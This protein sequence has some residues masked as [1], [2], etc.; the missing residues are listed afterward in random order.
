MWPWT[1]KLVSPAL[2]DWLQSPPPPQ[3]FTITDSTVRWR[4]NTLLT[5]GLLWVELGTITTTP[6]FSLSCR[7]WCY[8][9]R[10]LI[11]AESRTLHISGWKVSHKPDPHVV[12]S[13]TR[14]AGRHKKNLPIQEKQDRVSQ[15]SHSSSMFVFQSFRPLIVWLCECVISVWANWGLLICLHVLCWV[16]TLITYMHILS[17]SGPGVMSVFGQRVCVEVTFRCK[18]KARR[19]DARGLIQENQD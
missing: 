19:R 10:S 17:D 7:T 3:C 11:Q 1:P 4:P 13:G 12:V 5:Q 18:V 9:H 16:I 14:P 6:T 8:W 15:G 2:G